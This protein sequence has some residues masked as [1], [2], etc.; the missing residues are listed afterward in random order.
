[1]TRRA[2]TRTGTGTGAGTGTGTGGTPATRLLAEHGVPH[3]VHPY[4]HDPGST[5][6]YGLEAAAVL[7]VEPEQVF[8]TLV[9]TVDGD[10]W[11]AVVP[12]SGQLDLKA[13]AHAAGGRRA[14]LADPAAAERATG[15]VVGGISPLA[16]RRALPTVLD[17]TVWLYDEV[18]VSGG[19]RGLDVSLPP[20]DL[21]ALTGARVA[22]IARPGRP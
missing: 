13:L 8:K 2:A 11:V 21:V 9:A 15:Y 12:V 18:Y 10:L 7:G 20:A 22:D 17:E 3:R 16:Q 19:R 4:A 6:G 1:M 14:V 5:V